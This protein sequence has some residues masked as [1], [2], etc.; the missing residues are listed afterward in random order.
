MNGCV[1]V[2]HAMTLSVFLAFAPIAA[3]AQES[4]NALQ[5]DNV[6]T[7]VEPLVDGTDP[8]KPFT[9]RLAIDSRTPVDYGDNV[10]ISVWITPHEILEVKDVRIH[11]KGDLTTIY[12]ST[13]RLSPDLSDKKL[14]PRGELISGASCRTEL[15]SRPAGVPFVATC[16]LTNLRSGLL[17]WFD[18]SALLGSGRQQ[19]EIEINLQDG[20]DT[21]T[22]FEFGGVDFVSP[23]S[24]VI[25]GGFFGALL[26]V[27]FLNM[28]AP[29]GTFPLTPIASWKDMFA[30]GM[31][32][33]PHRSLVFIR[34][35]WLV[36][37][38]A[39]LG[40]ATALVLIVMANTTEGFEPPISI[41]IQDFW[42][43][44]MVGLLSVQLSKWI[45]AKLATIVS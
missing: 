29:L 22:Y 33:L 32:A 25:L 34:K 16:Q 41:R 44:M 4:D 18:V 6:A 45:R 10:V 40:G 43:G 37:R 24:A 21:S 12:Q 27:L 14:Y 15:T 9:A 20:T 23:K 19:V 30:R 17:R 3:H 36:L 11:P 13:E 38:S 35:T 2:F 8:G 5:P 31:K 7:P 42:G 1:Q 39:L 28:S 26:W